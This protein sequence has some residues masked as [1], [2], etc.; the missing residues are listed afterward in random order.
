MQFRVKSKSLGKTDTYGTLQRAQQRAN[1]MNSVLRNNHLT[2]D[3]TVEP[4]GPAREPVPDDRKKQ[5]P[6]RI[7]GGNYGGNKNPKRNPKR[8]SK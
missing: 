7:G 3:A 1:E 8:G 5:S 6:K 2:A 4:I